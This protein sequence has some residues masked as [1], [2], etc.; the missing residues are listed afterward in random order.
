MLLLLLIAET[1]FAQRANTAREVVSKFAPDL[2]AVAA[3]AHH[4]ASATQTVK[5]LG[6]EQL[7]HANGGKGVTST[8]HVTDS[9]GG[10]R[11]CT[12]VGG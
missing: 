9:T 3:R 5:V 1:A 2:A 7:V 8:G 10:T 11:C 6:T 12:G 4:N